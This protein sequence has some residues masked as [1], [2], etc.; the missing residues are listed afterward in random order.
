[1][2][3][4]TLT[5]THTTFQRSQKRSWLLLFFILLVPVTP[6]RRHRHNVGFEN[7]ICNLSCRVKRFLCSVDLDLPFTKYE[8]YGHN[9]FHNGWNVHHVFMFYLRNGDYRAF[10]KWQNIHLPLFCQMFGF[11]Y[12][13]KW[14]KLL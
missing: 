6:N 7:D 9:V 4:H 2:P 10:A 5:H 12:K 14:E 3:Q 8:W 1:M 13:G 11:D